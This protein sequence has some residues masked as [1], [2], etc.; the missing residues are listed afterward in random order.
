LRRPYCHDRGTFQNKDIK[1][2][3]AKTGWP[4]LDRDSPEDIFQF[5]RRALVKL[6]LFLELP[7]GILA[8]VLVI[9]LAFAL[10]LDLVLILVLILVP[11]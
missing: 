10:A 8:R 5:T 1:L 3:A 2:P 11:V 4:R 6:L 9:I 7:S